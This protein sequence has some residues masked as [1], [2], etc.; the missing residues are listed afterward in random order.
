MENSK[1]IFSI[2][3]STYNYGQ[4]IEEAID[5]ILNQTFPRE[6]I[7]IIVIDD[8]STDDTA[9]R[10]KKYEGKIK[11]IYQKNA[12]QATG[13]N[14]GFKQSSGEIIT[15]MDADDYWFPDK[16]MQVNSIYD[17]YSY[18]AVFHDLTMVGQERDGQNFF[19]KYHLKNL[20]K[21][22]DKVYILSK[23]A[24][25]NN[26]IFYAITTGQSYKRDLY[27]KLYPIPT[28]Y[29]WHADWYL[30]IAALADSD[31]CLL[32]LSLGAYR[33]HA[34]NHSI[35]V[36]KRPSWLRRSILI[37]ESAL[38]DAKD[39]A[40]DSDFMVW[41]IEEALLVRNVQLAKMERNIAGILKNIHYIFFKKKVHGSLGFR[42]FRKCCL[43]VY[44]FIP[45]RIASLLVRFYIKSGLL[46]LRKNII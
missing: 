46:S 23:D 38:A 10:L 18:D 29:V 15:F 36:S 28:Y 35:L 22:E 6:K 3:I 7:E 9:F 45:E 4:F 25:I 12:G 42:I 11:Y 33:R 16:L 24:H 17:K 40:M 2:I 37:F 1:P 34:G 20:K 8:G 5:S 14:S 39:A 41:S 19:N 30:F 26:P 32:D 44:F 13:L 43:V 21:I 31:I 27:E